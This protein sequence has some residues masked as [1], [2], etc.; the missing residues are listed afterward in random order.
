MDYSSGS[1]MAFRDTSMSRTG[2]VTEPLETVVSNVPEKRG[3]V[4]SGEHEPARLN[5]SVEENLDL[6][7]QVL[8]VLRGTGNLNSE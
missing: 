2:S 3:T 8:D 6:F 1:K 4:R 7:D 5:A